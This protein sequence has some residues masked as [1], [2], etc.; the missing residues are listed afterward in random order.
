MIASIYFVIIYLTDDQVLICKNCYYYYLQRKIAHYTI[1]LL[2][3]QEVCD[4]CV[5][6][7][8]PLFI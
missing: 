8:I 2:S 3:E 5:H 4:T 1:F 7:T 6:S